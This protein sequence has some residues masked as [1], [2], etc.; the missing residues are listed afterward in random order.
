MVKLL[1][2][3]AHGED[4]SIF[5]DRN[6]KIG[7]RYLNFKRMYLNIQIQALRAVYD[8]DENEEKMLEELDFYNAMGPY[9]DPN[10]YARKDKVVDRFLAQIDSWFNCD[11][12]RKIYESEE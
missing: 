12:P 5:D 10:P 8:N 6:V 11:T 2:N 1:A 4:P 9:R 3:I 7:R